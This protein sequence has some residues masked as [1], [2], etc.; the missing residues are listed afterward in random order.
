MNERARIPV[1]LPRDNPTQSYWQDPP[2]GIADLRTT[3]DLPGNADVVI[4]GSGITGAAVA[5]SLLQ[6]GNGSGGSGG[7]DIS[8]TPPSVVMLEARQACSGATGRNG[9]HTKA[10]SYRSFLA[11]TDAL[12]APAAAKIA[13]LEL[14]NIDAVHAFAREH[15]IPCDS[16]PCRTV[17]IIYDEPHWREAHEA[18]QAMRAALG[19]DD[20]A[21]EYTFHD[22]EEARARFYCAG[23]DADREPV[24]AV[25]YA[26][27]SIS[28]YGFG[29]GVLKLAL[30][31]GL[32]LQTGTPAVSL[33]RCADGGGRWEVCT[34]RGRVVTD[35]V[36]LA[37]NGYTAHLWE[38]FQ[39]AI[40][41]LRGQ[42]TA[43]RPGANMP[44]DGLPTTY[45]FIY[46]NGYEYMVPRPPG[47]R[48]AGDI[49]IGG[50]LVRAPREG[51]LE[52]GT[53]DDT[54]V[55]EDISAYLREATVRCFGRRNWGEDHP[56]GRVRREWTGIM[57]YSPDGLPFVGKV[58]G[59]SGGL[60]ASCSF[61]GHGMVLCW[62]CARAMVRMMRGGDGDLDGWFPREFVISEERLRKRFRGRL[63]TS[64]AE[65]HPVRDDHQ[66]PARMDLGLA[67]GPP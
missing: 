60:W 53:T 52:Y 8:S 47:S 42:V 4:I 64:A 62:M 19:P 21:A 23:A 28:G 44:R 63:H 31:G 57:G 54:T 65:D 25:S 24:G 41:P 40:V 67:P 14:A 9:G 5:W 18:V 11:N 10:A 32:N 15:A 58:P 49:V 39:G 29:V 55:D 51:L 50:G 48:H 3:P 26:A 2:D 7:S 12:G 20:P 56:G 43:Q 30:A 27:G 61:Q 34:P 66:P 33:G 59:S 1:T 22:A 17:D 46:E 35:K 45:S 38:A 16:N 6:D 13:R 37:T 36:V